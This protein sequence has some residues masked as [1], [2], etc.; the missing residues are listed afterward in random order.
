MKNISGCKIL[1]IKAECI[2]PV[3]L[4]DLLGDIKGDITSPTGEL[5]A[6][7]GQ[8]LLELPPSKNDAS[9]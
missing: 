8:K 1:C 2:L 5:P 9:L 3:E 7:C 6:G 4:F